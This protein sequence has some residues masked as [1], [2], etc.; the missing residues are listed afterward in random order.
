MGTLVTL[1]GWSHSLLQIE[2]IVRFATWVLRAGSRRKK[3]PPPVWRR[4]FWVRAVRLART[5]LSLELEL[6]TDN[7]F[8][9]RLNLQRVGQAAVV[10]RLV[11][12][13]AGV[14]D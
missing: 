12:I 11:H 8:P 4:A 3:S 2:V 7:D 10:E 5:Q 1:A 6:Y 14:I 9:Q 13:L